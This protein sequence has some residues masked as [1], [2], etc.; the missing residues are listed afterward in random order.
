MKLIV[1]QSPEYEEVF[2]T[3]N[4]SEIDSS[5]QNIINLIN[6]HSFTIPVKQGTITRQISLNTIFYFE[7][8][9]NKT[10][11]Y[12]EQE[13]FACPLKL[14]ELEKKLEDTAFLRIS[15]SCILNLDCLIKV[16][17]LLNGKYEATLTNDE[18]VIITR[19][20]VAA[21]KEKMEA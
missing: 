7:S 4:C 12:T 6:L 19:H 20:Y 5:L 3:V 9:D 10:Y 2:I 13:V 21:F 11:V 16:K 1:N 14:Y 8:V 17:A 15:K 18:K